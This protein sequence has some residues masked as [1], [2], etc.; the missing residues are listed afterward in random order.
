MKI[1]ISIASY[2][3]PLTLTTIK[4]ALN[5]AKNPENIVIGVLDQT[6][7]ILKDLPDNVRYKS[8]HPKESK[9]ACWARRKIQTDLFEGEDIDV[10]VPISIPLLA[11]T[12]PMESMLVTSS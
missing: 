11:V 7:D 1:F 2:Q 3:D 12:I 9:G 6:V 10:P 8:L 5:N 4:S